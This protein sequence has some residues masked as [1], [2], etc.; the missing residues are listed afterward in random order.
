MMIA[1]SVVA[2]PPLARHDVLSFNYL[3]NKALCAHLAAGGCT[4]R[5]YGGNTLGVRLGTSERPAPTAPGRA[6]L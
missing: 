5:L 2:V 1:S 6:A 4:T 3:A